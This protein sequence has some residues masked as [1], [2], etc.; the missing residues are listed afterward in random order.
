MSANEELYE[1]AARDYV[2]HSASNAVNVAYERPAMYRVIGD[3][4]G[5][6]VLDAG[7]AGG[8][9]ADRLSRA[10]ADVIAIDRSQAM[11][12]IARTRLAGTVK[13]RR[14]DLS[15][16]MAWQPSATVDLIV[17]SL[18]L[19]YLRDWDVP[20]R[21]FNRILKPAGRLVLSTHHPFM[22]LPMVSDYFDLTLVT[23]RWTLG[24]RDH[25]VRFY[26]RPM[27]AILSALRD[28]GFSLSQLL[29]PRMGE[30]A[31]GL[32]DELYDQLRL[33]PWFLLIDARPRSR[34]GV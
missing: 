8:E 15:D 30:R 7:C 1:K 24:A 25:E 28:A 10:G 34:G 5:M 9:Y 21:E 12:E 13:T 11:I 6:T 17:C 16:P 32:S 26:H 4:A 19:H 33:R 20:L 14:H 27:Q 23:D 3:V 29:E 2:E 22:T 31:Q 18:T